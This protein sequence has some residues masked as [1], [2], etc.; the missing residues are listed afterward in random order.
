MKELPILFNGEMVKAILD[1]RKTQTRRPIKVSKKILDFWEVESVNSAYGC[2]SPI[3][4]QGEAALLFSGDQGY[5]FIRSPFG[6]AD[7]VLWVRETCRAVSSEWLDVVEYE[8]DNCQLQP[9]PNTSEGADLWFDLWS[10][11][12]KEG[13]TVPSIHMPKWAC[14]L[15]LKVKRVW[16]ERVQE[17]TED[18]AIS[19]GVDI[20]S[21]HASLMINM[22]SQPY[23]NDLER[24]S[25]EL[26]LFRNLWNS[27]Y[28]RVPVR[29]D[30][31][32]IVSYDESLAWKNN[33]WVWCCEFEV[34]K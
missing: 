28:D 26:T 31:G 24:G 9:M 18:G 2:L 23:P 30:D 27:I 25:V 7:D 4:Q 22:Q 29:D 34:I 10:Y 12:G 6:K 32:K 14:R 21:D 13:A 17:I 8:A 19:E 1:G 3:D 33:P 20:E 16:V 5:E 15:K 11:R